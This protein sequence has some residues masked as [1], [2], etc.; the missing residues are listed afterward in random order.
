MAD[1]DFRR[2]V[3]GCLQAV[4]PEAPIDRLDPVV[5]FNEQFDIDSVD[6]L[7]FVMGI[8]EALGI[9]IAEGDYPRLSSLNGCLALLAEMTERR[10]EMP[11]P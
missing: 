3:L 6:Y 4:A 7:N 10:G 5:S 9:R 11:V 8:E 1:N 2:I